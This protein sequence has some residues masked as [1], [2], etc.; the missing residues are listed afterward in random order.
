M[1]QASSDHP[2]R[3][4]RDLGLGKVHGAGCFERGR[5]ADGHR[6]L[7]R[8]KPRVGA[9]RKRRRRKTDGRIGRRRGSPLRRRDHGHHRTEHGRFPA[10]NR[11]VHR[12]A[13]FRS[14]RTKARPAA[15]MLP[16]LRRRAHEAEALPTNDERERRGVDGPE[17]PPEWKVKTHPLLGSDHDGGAAS[18]GF[19]NTST[20]GRSRSRIARHFDVHHQARRPLASR[21]CCSSCG[22]RCGSGS[23]TC[24]ASAP[25][26]SR[27]SVGRGR[28]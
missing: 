16:D 4:N 11:S 22:A 18:S 2:I 27:R 23:A 5:L 26:R 28:R 25:S 21:R 19:G 13:A 17:K 1:P 8:Q 6:G 9:R 24:P 7:D 20:G 3:G 12:H 10:E 15:I 14:T